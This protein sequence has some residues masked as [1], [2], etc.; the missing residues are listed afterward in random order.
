MD[1][2]GQLNQLLNHNRMLALQ[3]GIL[4]LK[5]RGENPT[6]NYWNGSTM[7]AADPLKLYVRLNCNLFY[8]DL[9][10]NHDAESAAVAENAKNAFGLD[11][12]SQRE[13]VELATHF[14]EFCNSLKYG[15]MP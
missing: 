7:I 6:Y 11:G 10:K 13:T 8:A 3:N 14:L 15:V 2:T 9:S 4:K 1:E 12:L 5:L